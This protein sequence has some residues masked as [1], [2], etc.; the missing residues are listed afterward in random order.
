MCSSDLWVYEAAS[1]PSSS[2]TTS[3]IV[4]SLYDSVQATATVALVQRDMPSELT[5]EWM[6]GLKD[7]DTNSIR[8]V[9]GYTV[10]R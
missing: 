9:T 1:P 6:I 8:A 2:E 4:A 5:Q 7:G 10:P 3:T